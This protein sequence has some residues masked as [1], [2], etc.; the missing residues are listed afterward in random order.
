MLYK[1]CITL[2]LLYYINKLIS[3]ITKFCYN[4]SQQQ[5]R[6]FDLDLDFEHKLW[7]S[8]GLH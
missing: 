4:K 6:D 7:M 8:Q 5:K 1:T 2:P 3:Y